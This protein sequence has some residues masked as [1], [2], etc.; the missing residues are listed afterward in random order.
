MLV[1][2]F[3]MYVVIMTSAN[4]ARHGKRFQHATSESKEKFT[5]NGYNCHVDALLMTKQ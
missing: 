1:C 5:Q 4:E 3:T 2:Y